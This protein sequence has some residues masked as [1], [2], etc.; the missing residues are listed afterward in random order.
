LFKAKTA[1]FFEF[2]FSARRRPAAIPSLLLPTLR[3]P[4]TASLVENL[5]LVE[6]GH[7]ALI[8]WNRE[9]EFILLSKESLRTDAPSSDGNP[10]PARRRIVAL[11]LVSTTGKGLHFVQEDEPEAIG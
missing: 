1:K 9:F 5:N 10:V 3:R 2:P 7:F 11:T 6:T 8:K 4:L